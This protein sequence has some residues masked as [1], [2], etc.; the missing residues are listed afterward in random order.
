M[1]DDGGAW[2]TGCTLLAV[3]IGRVG[4]S[5]RSHECATQKTT[6]TPSYNVFV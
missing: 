4:L 2:S 5:K 3:L 1:L 6:S